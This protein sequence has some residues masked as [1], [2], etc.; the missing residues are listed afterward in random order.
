MGLISQ[1]GESPRPMI[2]HLSHC[3][4]G[5]GSALVSWNGPAFWTPAAWNP[6]PPGLNTANLI[7]SPKVW[8]AFLWDATPC[9]KSLCLGAKRTATWP[10][11]LRMG[12]LALLAGC[13]GPRLPASGPGR[14]LLP[15]KPSGLYVALEALALLQNISNLL[16]ASPILEGPTLRHFWPQIVARTFARSAWERIIGWQQVENDLQAREQQATGRPAPGAMFGR[17]WDQPFKSMVVWASAPNQ[18]R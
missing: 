1:A 12:T 2:D 13:A 16:A 7:P 8:S 4:S 15:C 6:C 11:P 5:C 18:N 3:P 9:P 17:L 14:L 10:A